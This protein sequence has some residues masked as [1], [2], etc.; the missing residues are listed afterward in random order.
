MLG[1]QMRPDKEGRYGKF[2]GKYVPE[3]LIP[4]LE[5]LTVEYER[6]MK[7]ESFKVVLPLNPSRSLCRMHVVSSERTAAPP[8]SAEFP[9]DTFYYMG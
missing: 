7:D 4:A 1:D 9:V 3:T 8:V 6:A 5:D 2:G